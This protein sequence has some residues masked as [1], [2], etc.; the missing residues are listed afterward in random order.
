MVSLL[1]ELGSP[2]VQSHVP[3]CAAHAE[4]S[5]SKPGRPPASQLG[6]DSPGQQRLVNI[7]LAAAD[8]LPVDYYLIA[9]VDFDH[10][11]RDQF[12]RFNGLAGLP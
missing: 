4:T 8:N 12:G 7:Y 9:R 6:R 1:G 11:A 10:V 3:G 5:W 2:D